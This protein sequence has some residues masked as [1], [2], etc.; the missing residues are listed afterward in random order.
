MAACWDSRSVWFTI[1]LSTEESRLSR[2]LLL[3]RVAHSR[4]S[5]HPTLVQG[6]PNAS[7]YPQQLGFSKPERS[8]E[9][10]RVLW[11]WDLTLGSYRCLHSALPLERHLKKLK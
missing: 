7:V 6:S 3:P 9:F 2:L 10:S 11:C 4:G 1:L 5:S 8:M